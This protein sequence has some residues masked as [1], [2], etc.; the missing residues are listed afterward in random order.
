MKNLLSMESFRRVA[1]LLGM[2]LLGSCGKSKSG[3][4]KV[5]ATGGEV[6]Q[7]AGQGTGLVTVSHS[8]KVSFNQDIQPLL[9][10]YCYHCHGPDA[11]HRQPKKDPIRLDLEEF[12]FQAHDGGKPVIIAGDAAGSLVVKLMHEKDPD[13]VMPKPEGHKVMKPEEI[14][15][16][17]RWINEGAKYEK[18]WAFVTPV[19]AEIPQAD[20]ALVKNPIDTF[21]QKGLAKLGLKPAEKEDARVLARRSALDVTGLLPDPTM[22]EEF[23]KDPSDQAYD[24]YLDKLLSTSAYAEHR[25]RYWLDYARYAD[26]HGLHFDNYRAIWPYRDY[27]IRSFAQNKPFD[28]FVR[29]QIAGDQLPQQ[30]L[31]AIV[32]TGYI[33]SNVSTNEGGTIPEEIHNANTRDR[34]EAFGATFLGL[35][36][37]CAACHDHKFDPTSQKD[38]YSIGAFFNNTSEQA[39]DNALDVYSKYGLGTQYSNI[40]KTE[41]YLPIIT[42]PTDDKLVAMNETISQR[43]VLTAQCETIKQRVDERLKQSI[44]AGNSPKLVAADQLELELKLGEGKDKVAHNTAVGAKTATYSFEGNPPV[45]NEK[46]LLW[47]SMRM[48]SSTILPMIDQGDF[49]HN[50]AFSGSFW[51]TVRMVTSN[52][53]TG[54]GTLISRMG[55]GNR[56]KSRGW[57][58][59]VV[60]DKLQFVIIH[61]WPEH[62]IG[63]EVGNVPRGEWAHIGFSYDG[64]GKS[65]GMKL[66]LN[67]KA[68]P[69][70]LMQNSLLADQSVQTDA[71]LHLG[72]RHDETNLLRETIFQ[73]VRLY[74]RQLSDVEFGQ[75][76]YEHRTAELLAT[77]PD[78]T[79]WNRTD[80]YIGLQKYYLETIDQEAIKLNADKAVVDAKIIELGVGGQP[81]MI[82]QEQAQPAYSW[83]LD[84]G[85]YSNLKD[86]VTPS[87]PHFITNGLTPNTI[88]SRLDLANWL[89][90]AENP[91]FARVTVNRMWQELFGIGLV[92][93]PNDF[94]LMGGRPV[95]QE[96]LDWLAVELRESG[97]NMKHIY[98]LILSSH[99][100]RQSNVITPEKLEKDP[101]NR[102]ISRGPRFRMDAEL[103][104][105]TALQT[106]GL[107]NSKVGGPPARPYQPDGIWETV[108]MP[109]SDT[110]HYKQDT[111]EGLYRRSMYSFWKRFAPPPSLE[112]FDAE[113]RE[114]VCSHRARTNTP[115]Q[116]LVS[117]ND[118]QFVEA[119]RKL[120]ERAISSATTTDERLQFIAQLLLSRSLTEKEITLLKGKLADFSANYTNNNQAVTELLSVGAMP[121]NPAL[122]PTEVAAWTLVAN[123][124][125]NLDE[126]LTK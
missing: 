18:H 65:E 44:A 124:F 52:A 66:L 22:V 67:G 48:N 50:Q 12:A 11:S 63:I 91:L 126:S 58:I 43:A 29:E 120:A 121:V 2:V 104:R 31:D 114:V 45:W 3:D 74:R 6:A 85:V 98:K 19:K 72:R 33:R 32:A 100:Y 80:R 13:L 20:A 73:D 88:N 111:G 87:T 60:G 94:G 39:W 106:A 61:Q 1:M 75:L 93:T 57:D 7:Q 78:T 77:A 95:N 5:S 110:L 40:P 27:V 68:L 82:T 38:F 10:E 64:S 103:L 70:M 81:T 14:A 125:L 83:T 109:E 23:V 4:S 42:I 123:S 15:L 119:A 122:N 35:T 56:N 97:W 41:A 8:E 101:A 89:F 112:T 90:T 92:D 117:M 84:R 118:P 51:T 79:T 37:G 28:Q 55:D 47:N 76:L 59:S 9:S 16:I 46:S 54:N 105:D 62:W 69:A 99:A 34:A 53:T 30:N 108:S 96:L 115:L 107:L 26:T 36:V 102:N 25:T 49:A 116:A 21:V 86:Q 17:E 71:P 113:A 24:A